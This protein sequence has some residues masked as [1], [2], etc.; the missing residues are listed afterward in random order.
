MTMGQKD[1]KCCKCVFRWEEGLRHGHRKKSSKEAEKEKRPAYF[2]KNF[3]RV[4]YINVEV[5][6]EVRRV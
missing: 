5:K 6:I 1:Q 2:S 4:N 3:T